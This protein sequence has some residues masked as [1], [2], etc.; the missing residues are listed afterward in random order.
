[1]LPFIKIHIYNTNLTQCCFSDTDGEEKGEEAEKRRAE[2]KKKKEVKREARK[3]SGG[4]GGEK[5]EKRKGKK[6]KLPGQPKRALSAYFLWM[7]ENRDKIKAENPGLS[8]G[9]LGKKFGEL[10]KNL[11]SKS[12]SLLLI[13]I[14]NLLGEN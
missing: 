12:V 9:D 14:P 1:M 10:W 3:S 5:R 6:V 13:F 4:G 11:S 2:R 7:N 8:I